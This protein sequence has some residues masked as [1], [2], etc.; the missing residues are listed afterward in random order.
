[1]PGGKNQVKHTTTPIPDVLTTLPDGEVSMLHEHAWVCALLHDGIGPEDAKV[2][3]PHPELVLRYLQEF[4]PE[5]KAVEPAQFITTHRAV[6]LLYNQVYKKKVTEG[7][8]DRLFAKCRVKQALI[9]LEWG[10]AEEPSRK[11]N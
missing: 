8:M 7:Y 6:N 5:W 10:K 2:R 4:D 9:S 11:L 1:M 3:T